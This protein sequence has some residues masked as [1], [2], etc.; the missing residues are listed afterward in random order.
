MADLVTLHV[1]PNVYNT[2]QVFNLT[3]K[4]LKCAFWLLHATV[5]FF[6]WLQSNTKFVES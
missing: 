6:C 5:L 2:S 3:A 4:K 1:F